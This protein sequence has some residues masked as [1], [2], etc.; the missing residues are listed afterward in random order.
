MKLNTYKSLY[1]PSLHA[2]D[3]YSECENWGMTARLTFDPFIMLG[4]HKKNTI[5]QPT[6]GHIT[7]PKR[8]GSNAWP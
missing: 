8:H 4:L 6:S 7:C 3:S 1:I 5:P 2:K